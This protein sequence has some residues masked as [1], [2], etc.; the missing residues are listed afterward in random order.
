RVKQLRLRTESLI[1]P[2]MRSVRGLAALPGLSTLPVEQQRLQLSAVLSQNPE[3]GILSRF[4]VDGQRIP[5]LQGF[6]VQD[7]MPTE[8]VAHETRALAMIAAGGRS[9]RASEVAIGENGR[10]SSVTVVVPLSEDRGYLAAELL[11]EAMEAMLAQERTGSDGL[12]YL[13]DAAGRRV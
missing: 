8:L 1:D 10:P 2:P 13:V 5:G 7:V 11:L 4:D 12:A 6:A 9:L 3:I